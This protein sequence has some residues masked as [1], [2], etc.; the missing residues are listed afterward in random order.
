MGEGTG[1]NGRERSGRGG[2]YPVRFLNA[3]GGE[4]LPGGGVVVLEPTIDLAQELS[5]K[6][7]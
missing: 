5:G 1:G 6:K 2:G 3:G 4:G 7:T